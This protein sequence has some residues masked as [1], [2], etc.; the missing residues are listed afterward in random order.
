MCGLR[1][2][3][4]FLFPVTLSHETNNWKSLNLE[5]SH[6]QKYW[7][8]EIPTRKNFGPTSYPQ[9]KILDPREKILDP[10]HTHEEKFW[11][12]KIPTRKKFGPT[13]YPREKTWWHNGTMTQ[14]HQT[15]ETH[16]GTWPTKF[17]TPLLS[18][19]SQ[20][21]FQLLNIPTSRSSHQRYSVKRCS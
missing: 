9:E 17:S 11:T 20:L 19:T 7:T 4:V 3:H 2:I 13:K 18:T 8:H 10:R 15:Q 1:C 12:H 21:A 16:D 6:D 14:W 5:I